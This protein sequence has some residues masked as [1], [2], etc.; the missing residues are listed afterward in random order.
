MDEETNARN[1]IVNQKDFK[2]SYTVIFAIISVIIFIIMI[3]VGTN[4]WIRFV[5][6]VSGKSSLLLLVLWLFNSD[7]HYD[8]FE[9]RV[10]RFVVI[11]F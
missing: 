8:L 6:D 7:K 5:H 4:D 3:F 10:N 1:N 2:I 9:R 11:R